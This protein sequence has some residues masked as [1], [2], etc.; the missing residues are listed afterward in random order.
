MV[1]EQDVISSEDTG[2]VGAVVLHFNH[3]KLTEMCCRAL[4]QQ[5]RQ[6]DQ[7]LVVDNGS[8][9]PLGRALINLGPRIRVIHLNEN[10]GFAGGVNAGVDVLFREY[11]VEYIWLINNDVECDNDVL[12][13]ML[14]QLL[15][16]QTMAA[17]GC[18]L[19][20]KSDNGG[21][22]TVIGGRFPYP[23]LVP[24]VS[25]LGD[26]VDYL[27]GACLLLRSQAWREVGGMDTG[28]FF[29]FED[30]DWSM[31][32]KQR[33]WTL[34]VCEEVKARHIRSATIGQL[35][36]LRG[37]YYRQSYVRFLHHYSKAP[38]LLG[39]STT[40]YRLLVEALQRHWET[41]WGTWEGWCKGRSDLRSSTEPYT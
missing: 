18:S 12:A 25:T 33:G 9:E 35:P 4:L 11:H 32:A 40:V 16:M 29:F 3:V 13:G 21:E 30:A 6:V 20:E 41:F 2:R 5:T 15:V 24:E 8:Q 34:G 37:R 22:S 26:P 14:D 39:A 23:I 31:R 19:I 28:Y 36:R 1:P 10:L 17:I 7:I 38:F 27:C